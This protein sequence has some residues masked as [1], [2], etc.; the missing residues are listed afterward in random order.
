MKTDSEKPRDRPCFRGRG[1][2]KDLRMAMELCYTSSP[3]GLAPGTHGF[4]TVAAS[5][6]LTQPMAQRLEALSGYRPMFGVGDDRSAQNPV[7]HA[8]VRLAVGGATRSVLSRVAYAGADYSGRSNKF[9][10]H[11]LVADDERAAAGPAW[12]LSQPGVMREGWSGSPRKLD[13]PRPLPGGEAGPWVC[14]RWEDAAG[15]AGW[16]G[17][18]VE[19][20]LLDPAKPSYIVYQPDRHDA[21]AL[22]AE[23]VALLP[24]ARRW[25]A[26]FTTYFTDPPGE[27]QCAWRWV[28][29]GSPMAEQVRSPAG[30]GRVIDL[31]RKLAAPADSRFVSAARLGRDDAAAGVA[32]PEAS[33]PESRVPSVPENEAH[34]ATSPPVAAASATHKPPR[35]A[36]EPAAPARVP[37]EPP[38]PQTS[39]RSR[40]LVAWAIAGPLLAFGGAYFLF[41]TPP[42][43]SEQVAADDGPAL[44]ALAQQLA[45]SREHAKLTERELALATARL[46]AFDHAPREDVARDEAARETTASA[47]ARGPRIED[48][49]L[50]ETTAAPD[51]LSAAAEPERPVEV[52]INA[53]EN[54]TQPAVA[55]A[56]EATA[57]R[58]YAELPPPRLENPTAGGLGNLSRLIADEQLLWP[59]APGVTPVRVEAAPSSGDPAS[60]VRLTNHAG[61]VSIEHTRVD[62]LGNTRQELLGE[63][64][65]EPRGLVWRWRAETFTPDPESA[66]KRS[67]ADGGEG[68]VL[69]RLHDT[70]RFSVFTVRDG[71]GR[72]V[73]E[74]QASSPQRWEITPDDSPRSLAPGWRSV[75]PTLA[76]RDAPDGWTVRESKADGH[77]V[78]VGPRG[79][80]L[81]LTLNR[82]AE[83]FAARWSEDSE[84][85]AAARRLARALGD[86]AA[87]AETLEQ[88]RTLRDRVTKARAAL[89]RSRGREIAYERRD[90]DRWR[91]VFIAYERRRNELSNFLAELP[92]GG[93]AALREESGRLS[94]KIAADQTRQSD[95][96]GFDAAVFRLIA[97]GSHADLAII[98]VTKGQP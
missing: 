30:S 24:V 35:P 36:A 58:I 83:T 91:S 68:D 4:C 2:G 14:A 80:E 73:A 11:L 88:H 79:A 86:Q 16:A 25:D 22:T 71:D 67:F 47:P 10:H 13:N 44:A 60:T 78:L 31:T 40:L 48:P 43:T 81:H 33:P 84:P 28:V 77:A 34:P 98:E 39:P 27:A 23:A 42:T 17:V 89:P 9:A 46:A 15:D 64:R 20:F 19:W 32:P 69:A 87:H 7:A 63:G 38:A 92:P 65:A 59:A 26:T 94:E 93:I 74:V 96:A 85:E 41:S 90:E 82:H 18:L 29:D 5:A 95:V 12:V 8:H 56:P 1:D 37:A 49:Q 61:A 54:I 76:L 51:T 6:G 75:S 66:R 70:V 62:A 57:A 97:R 3:E 72:V 53:L 55:P 50:P 45:D 52:R 21:L